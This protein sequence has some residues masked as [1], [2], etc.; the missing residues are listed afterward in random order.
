MVLKLANLRTEKGPRAGLVIGAEVLVLESVASDF[1]QTV[2]EILAA[3]ETTF[4]RLRDISTT[5]GKRI[6]LERASLLAPVLKPR[7]FL[8]LGMNYKKHLEEV[9]KVGIQLPDHQYWFN[10]QVTC[11][12]GPYD[13]VTKPAVSDALDYEVEL[14]LVIGRRAKHVKAADAITVIAGYTIC[15]DFSVRDWQRHTPTFTMG[16]SFD[17][18]GPIGPWLVTADEISDPQNLNL[19]CLVNGVIV[20]DSNTKD[21]IYSCAEMIEYLSTAFTLE[22]GDVIATGTPEG[23]GGSKIPPVYL[24]AGDIVRCEIDCIGYI[25]NLIV[26]EKF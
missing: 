10:K 26:P 24:K 2:D 23:V 1:P 25:E 17:T 18:H 20:Q 9:K 11:V 3:G 14:A 4:A 6:P 15:N 7:K 16:K 22:P 12:N 21:M 13:P 19:R 5:A 8:A